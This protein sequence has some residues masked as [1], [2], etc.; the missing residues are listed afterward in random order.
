MAEPC[1]TVPLPPPGAQVLYILV[2]YG[3]KAPP[4]I[5]P[6]VAGEWLYDLPVYCLQPIGRMKS[7][8]ADGRSFILCDAPQPLPMWRLCKTAGDATIAGSLLAV[9]ERKK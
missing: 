9:V 8:D 6:P 3:D 2:V 1:Y 7:F 5:D 4:D